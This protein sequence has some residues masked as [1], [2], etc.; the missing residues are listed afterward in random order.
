MLR[1][2]LLAGRTA[3]ICTGS[4]MGTFVSLDVGNPMPDDA[5]VALGNTSALPE[6]H[7]SRYPMMFSRQRRCG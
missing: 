4:D 3:V 6:P 1:Q 5:P 7:Y 2:T